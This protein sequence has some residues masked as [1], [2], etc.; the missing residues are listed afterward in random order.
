V[1]NDGEGNLSGYAWSDTAGWLNFAPTN[2]GVEIDSEGVFSGYAWGENF[3]WLVFNCQDLDVC[4]TSDFK[5][6][7]TWLPLS[8]RESNEEDQD[9]VDVSDVRYSSTDTTIVINW[10]TNHNADSH[11]RWGSDKNLEKEKN[12]ND[13]EKKHRVVLRELEPDTGYYFRVK[14][15]DGNDNSDSSRIYSVSTKSSSAIFAKRQWESFDK[16]NGG[17]K[18]PEKVEVKVTDKSEAEIKKEEASETKETARTEMPEN[19]KPSAI[20]SFFSSVKNNIGDFLSGTREL[21]LNGQRKISEFFSWTGDQIAVVYDSLVSKISKEK[22]NQIARI[23]QAKFFTTQVFNRDEKKFL[24]EVRFQILDKSENP[25]PRLET[26]LFSDPKT[27]VTDEN[28]IASFK[29]VPLGSHTLAFDYQGE[30]FEKKVA[31]AD[32]LTD[33]GKVRAE[34][35]QVKAE[36]EKI[37]AWMWGIIILLI[38]AVACAAYFAG[39][40]YHLKKNEE[41]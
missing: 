29:D 1:A 9:G 26:T 32:T 3:G 35:V 17:E 40:Y 39:K 2:G 27:T 23:N 11:V 25:I 8:A 21:A 18:I 15:T 31:I 38:L 30:N 34:V 24:A 5:V 12:D 36:K 22:A 14:S 20:A 10:D 41:R 16:E 33:E 4:A 13:K 19:Q 7:T 28:G 6:K 37:A